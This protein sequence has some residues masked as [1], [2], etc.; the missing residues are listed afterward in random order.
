MVQNAFSEDCFT[1]AMIMQ[2]LFRD[3]EEG[4]KRITRRHRGRLEHN[5]SINTDF[6][7][8]DFVRLSSLYAFFTSWMRMKF[9]LSFCIPLC[10]GPCSCHFTNN[11]SMASHWGCHFRRIH[12]FSIALVAQEQIRLFSGFRTVRGIRILSSV[13]NTIQNVQ[14]VPVRVLNLSIRGA[15]PVGVS[16]W[17]LYNL[18]SLSQS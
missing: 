10:I 12:P 13:T 9:S 3:D 2:V 17:L 18:V 8:L 4:R 5:H 7:S 11:V 14:N 6:P 15:S 16:T 1:S